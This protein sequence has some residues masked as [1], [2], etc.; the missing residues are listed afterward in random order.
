MTN[1]SPLMTNEHLCLLAQQGD[2]SAQD[3]LIKNFISSMKLDAAALKKKYSGLQVEAEDLLQEALIGFLRAVQTYRPKEGI[4]FQTYASAVTRHAMLD[5]IRKC[6]SDIPETGPIISLDDTPPGSDPAS[7][8]TYVDI[9]INEYAASPEQLYIKKETILEVREVLW[10][11]SDR[12]REYLFFA[13]GLLMM[14]NTTGQ[15]QHF[16]FIL[17]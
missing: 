16:T 2:S 12:E 8:F 15:K 3:K 13:T 9:L 5:Y 10:M 11:I 1:E 14:L 6:K 7:E 4:Q 17:V